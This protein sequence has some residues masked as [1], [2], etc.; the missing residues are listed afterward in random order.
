MGPFARV[1]GHLV[2]P[3][4]G[5]TRIPFSAAIRSALEWLLAGVRSL[6]KDLRFARFQLPRT[7]TAAERGLRVAMADVPFEI[8]TPGKLLATVRALVLLGEVALHVRVQDGLGR[9]ALQI[10][11]KI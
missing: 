4:V 7:V 1:A 2:P 3:P 10:K 11:G 5:D 6:V 9:E 8:L